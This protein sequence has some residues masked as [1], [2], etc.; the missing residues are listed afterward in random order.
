[1]ALPNIGQRPRQHVAFGLLI[2]LEHPA[3]RERALSDP[4]ASWPSAF[5]DC[6]MW[7]PKGCPRQAGVGSMHEAQAGQYCFG[8]PR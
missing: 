8:D 2:L 4:R 3:H 5:V 1:M 7:L 6:R